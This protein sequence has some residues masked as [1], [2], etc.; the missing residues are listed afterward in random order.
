MNGLSVSGL[1]VVE[2]KDEAFGRFGVHVLVVIV[3]L[4]VVTPVVV[5]V[6]T[7][8]ALARAGVC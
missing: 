4:L 8:V 5:V 1:D 2:V 7:V 6:V 3:V